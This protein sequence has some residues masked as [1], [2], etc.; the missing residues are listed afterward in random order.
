M[1]CLLVNRTVVVDCTTT[2][3]LMRRDAIF[4]EWR[5]IVE[6]R[7]SASVKI[8]TSALKQQRNRDHTYFCRVSNSMFNFFRNRKPCEAL[9][10]EWL[11]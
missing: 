5:Q 1:S 10:C 8:A 11:P 3:S 6:S 9:Q 4:H 7:S 2:V